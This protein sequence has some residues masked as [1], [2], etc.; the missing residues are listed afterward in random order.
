MVKQTNDQFP[1]LLKTKA[2]RAALL[3]SIELTE[4]SQTEGGLQ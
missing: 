3:L 1:S 4:L 2:I